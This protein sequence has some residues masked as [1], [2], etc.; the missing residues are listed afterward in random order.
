MDGDEAGIKAGASSLIPFLEAGIQPRAVMLD[1]GMD[2]DSS[3][4]ERARRFHPTS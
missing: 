2:P 3:S 1:D 4:P